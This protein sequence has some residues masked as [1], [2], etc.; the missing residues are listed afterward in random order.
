MRIPRHHRLSR[1][2]LAPLLAAAT[3][4]A[5]PALA[6]SAG[7]IP[8]RP[9]GP[10]QIFTGLTRGP[11]GTDKLVVDCAGPSRFG[12]PVAG[13]TVEA[14]TGDDIIPG[15]TGSKANRIVVSFPAPSAVPTAA[16]VLR[17]YSDPQPIPISL[18]LPC[19]GSG[20]VTFAPKPSSKTA[21]PSLVSV[22]FEP[23]SG[24]G[25]GAAR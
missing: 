20:T 8:G 11:L 13:Q 2:A 24:V 17:Y 21:R 25:P 23:G 14:I 16:I 1:W 12:H 10:Y 5:T 9:V 4:A 6:G 3:S 18:T 22:T 19:D 7:A 15:Y